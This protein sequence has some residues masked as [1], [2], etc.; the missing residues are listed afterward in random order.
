MTIAPIQRLTVAEYHQLAADGRLSEANRVELIEGEL[1]AM[2]PIGSKHAARVGRLTR[3]LVF[4][5][6]T[7]AI[8]RVQSP[9]RLDDHSEPEPDVAVVWAREDFYES[10]HPTPDDVLLLVEVADTSL[11]FDLL[12]KA[13]LYARQGIPALWVFDERH[14]RMWLLE[15]PTSEGYRAVREVAS[16]EPLSIPGL[17]D[18]AIKAGDLLD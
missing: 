10:E 13:P 3:A 17:P 7:R 6:G 16:G 15:E 14:G 2:N 5:V 9:V 12:T 4:T 1:I 8:V 18:V 11:E